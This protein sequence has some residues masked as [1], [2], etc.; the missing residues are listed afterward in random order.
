M[1]TRPSRVTVRLYQVGFGDCFLLTF[2]YPRRLEDGRTE[3][4]LLIDFGSTRWP[5]P[6][7]GGYAEIAADVKQRTRGRLDAVVMTHRHKDHLGGFGDDRAAATIAALKPRVVLRPWTEDPAVARDARRPRGVGKG[8]ARLVAGLA[9]AQRFAEEV[10]AKVPE[11]A[12]GARGDL[13]D[14][15]DEQL[16]NEDAIQ[17]LDAM[18]DAGKGV[19]LHAGQ[20]S[21][22]EELLPGVEVSVLGPPTVEQCPA[23]ASQRA[24]D[25]EF[26]L[27]RRGLLDGMLDRVASAPRPLDA[28]AAEQAPIEP[29]PVRWLVERLREQELHSLL[30]IVRTLDD[31]LNNT[32]LVLLFKAGRR[33]MLF[34]GDAQIENWTYCLKSEDAADLRDGLDEVELYKVGHHGSRNATP[35]SLLAL[36]DSRPRGVTSIM[37]TMPGVHGHSEATAVP[38]SAL[39]TALRKL[40]PL[41]RTDDLPQGR[42]FV[43]VTARTSGAAGFAVAEPG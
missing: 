43:D 23:V 18:A 27:G 1:S 39:V 30:R 19:Y 38:R 25:P 11:G 8:S 31:A 21:G 13:R 34:P 37:S 16:P 22:L 20:P 9:A 28:A 4:H 12:R 6:R 7:A 10:T 32:S 2:S 15:A 5:K 35:R 26:W 29:G 24:N 42:L 17:A 41:V 14:M 3:R 33:R 40:G 36:W